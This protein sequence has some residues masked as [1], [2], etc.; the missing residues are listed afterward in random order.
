MSD[1]KGLIGPFLSLVAGAVILIVGLIEL[2]AGEELI[3]G[4]QQ[5]TGLLGVAAGFSIL[6]AAGF[7]FQF[8][9]H[10]AP[11][12]GLVLLLA[13]LSLTSDIGVGF[14]LAALGG[15]C[16]IAFEP[17]PFPFHSLSAPATTVGGGSAPQSA[18]VPDSEKGSP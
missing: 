2:T 8:P 5:S 16:L 14:L 4:V 11:I 17:G 18:A 6:V 15:T 1:E 12:G 9:E 10:H 7:S 13:F 3:L